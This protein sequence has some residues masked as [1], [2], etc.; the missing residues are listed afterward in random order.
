MKKILF[1]LLLPLLALTTFAQGGETDKDP[2]HRNFKVETTDA[3]YPGGDSALYRFFYDHMEYPED[4][5]KYGLEGD[6]T[7][8]F[9]VMED[10]T[11]ANVKAFND[12]GLGTGAEAERLVKLLKY[13]PATR[14]GRPAKQNMMVVVLF[15]IYD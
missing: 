15:R 12:L 1:L 4:A 5:K 6:I 10:G 7:V 14:L 2:E 3:S 11:T 9:D 8:G 13:N